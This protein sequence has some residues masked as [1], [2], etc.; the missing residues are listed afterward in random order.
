[1]DTKASQR[2]N[3]TQGCLE[4]TSEAVDQ[5][6]HKQEDGNQG[7]QEGLRGS[8]EISQDK[9]HLHHP[10]PKDLGQVMACVFVAAG[11]CTYK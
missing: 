2:A 3:W 9:Q 11:G 4:A 5:D 10:E 1:M 6:L 7:G 8:I